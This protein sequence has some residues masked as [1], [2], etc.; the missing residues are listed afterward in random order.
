M[1][2]ITGASDGLGLELAKLYKEAGEKVVNISRRKSEYADE[3]LSTDLLVE[4]EIEKAVKRILAI[5]EPIEVLVNC[6]GVMSLEPIDGI[7]ASEI[8]RTFGVNVRAAMLLVSGLAEQLK[9]DR[10]DIINVAS[11][12]GLK[13]YPDQAAYGAS[14]WA[15]R[16]FSQNLQ[17]ELKDTNRVVSFCV[18]GFNSDI[19]KKV[20][21]ND[22]PDPENWMNPGDI[23]KFMK[24][25]LDLPKSMEVSEVIINRKT[26]R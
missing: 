11:T 14:K 5:G 20:T 10:A 8:D 3:N 23:A 2:I 6:A 18:G 24:Q 1:I 19:A 21:G 15:M 9:Q 13:A 7:S 12:V 22:I 4:Q 26:S 16:G 25:I 17:V